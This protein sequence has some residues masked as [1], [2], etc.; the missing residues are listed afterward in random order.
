M[1][2]Y[3]KIRDKILRRELMPGDYLV[4][5]KLVE[6]LNMSRTPIRKAID[7]LVDEGLVGRV[8]NKCTFVKSTVQGELIMAYELCEALD[9]MAAYLLA[10]QVAKGTLADDDLEVLRQIASDLV[11][12]LN[13]KNMKRWA[14]LDKLF[15]ITL[16]MMSGNEFIIRAN[17]ENYKHINEILWFK[18]VQD[19]DIEGSNHMHLDMLLAISAGDKEKS[20]K[21]AQEHRRRIIEIMKGYQ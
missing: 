2:A 1:I 18:V 6:E 15:H 3:E 14:E 13:N 20:R 19:V 11:R 5:L 10:E 8:P 16:V 12:H 17:Q 21:I 4:E 9:G 7:M